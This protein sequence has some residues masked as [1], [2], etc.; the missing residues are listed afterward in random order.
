[1]TMKINDSS[2]AN[3]RESN[4]EL[5]RIIITLLIVAHHYW[6]HSGI[7]AEIAKNTYCFKSMYLLVF[8]A[9]GKTGINSFILITGFFY[10]QIK[11]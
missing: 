10:V 7:L 2:N 8:G 3:N 11:Y 4:I 9:W 1:M 5:Y 6:V